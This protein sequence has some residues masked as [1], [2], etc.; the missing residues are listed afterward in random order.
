MQE[1]T[2]PNIPIDNSA[3]ESLKTLPFSREAE[4][5][6]L[7]GLMLSNEKWISIAEI[8]T[9]EDFH[10]RE[11]QILFNAIQSLSE[12][13]NPCDAVTLS[14]WLQKHDQ[15]DAIGGGAY[16]G[17]LVGNT[18]S[19][20]NITA[21]ADIVRDRSILRQLVQVGTQI[22]ESA[23]N[24]QGRKTA[25]LLD[26][27]ERLVF[28]IAEKGKRSQTGFAKIDDILD[29][30]LERIDKLSQQEGITGISTGFK[31]LDKLT[32]GLQKSDLIIVAGRPSMGKCIA[33]DCK[34]MLADGHLATIEEIY[35]RKKAQLLTLE[36]NYQF[37]L[38]Q[39]TDFIYDGIKPVFRVTT[40]LGR[41]IETTLTHPFLTLQGWHPLS[42]I[43]VGEKIAVPRKI[44]VF[45]I[46]RLRECQ[47]KLSAYLIGDC[48]T[49]S[50][51]QIQKD[52]SEAVE[53]IGTDNARQ[54]RLENAKGK[55]IPSIIFKLELTQIALFLN[56]LFATEAW[57]EH[58][59]IVYSS[60]HDELIK[61]VQHLLLRFGII[62]TH[63][64]GCQLKILDTNSILIFIKKIGIFTKK[65]VLSDIQAIL[66]PI[67]PVKDEHE[68]YW[69]KIKAI[70]AVGLKP[71]YDLTIPETHNFVANDVCVHNTSFAMNLAEHAALHNK[72]PVAVFSMEMSNEQLAMRLISSLGK[73]NLQNVRTGNLEDNDWSQMIEAVSE[74]TQSYLFI[75]ET[76][77]LNPTELRSRARRLARE[78]GQL[79]LIVIDYLQ[80]MQVPNNK[81]N[82][83]NEVS[84]ISRALKS[85]AKEL[86]VPVVALSQ[87]NRSLEQR[88]NKRPIMSDLRESGEIEQSADLVLFIYRDEV[89]NEDSPDKGKAEIIIA[90]QRNGPIGTIILT[91]E[92]QFTR[93]E[94]NT[95]FTYHG[96]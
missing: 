48:Q 63:C 69:D 25:E 83:T 20:A 59:K 38:T 9:K 10:L 11:H 53:Q 67:A 70:E 4:Q 84:E 49:N 47:I 26:E 32:S 41:S 55:L 52:F 92:G 94:N 72:M 43:S 39:P 91:F 88:S 86:N 13:N 81:E 60:V 95:E 17:I 34:I 74:L 78:K 54:I 23:F 93:F 30:T 57:I 6:V 50:H 22:T 96:E 75:D 45:G 46:E 29:K 82:R 87:L 71:V 66:E 77:A 16:L 3:I 27:A 64:E 35:H 24:T 28:E 18:P 80:L 42:D 79:G 65:Q 19:A 40:D 61:Q 76:P 33:S 51:P 37:Y 7:G 12:E 8:V 15:L 68:I 21:Y 58:N 62:A 44:G 73:V 90:K 36:Q 2:Y 56:R 31:D 14:E 89:Y 85:L 1:P 5:S